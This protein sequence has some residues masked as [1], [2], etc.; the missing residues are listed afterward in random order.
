M[1][2]S[3]GYSKKYLFKK[4]MVP[5][6]MVTEKNP[7]FGPKTGSTPAKVSHVVFEQSLSNFQ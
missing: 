7:K 6:A 4:K 5:V 1:Y 2:Q 3:H